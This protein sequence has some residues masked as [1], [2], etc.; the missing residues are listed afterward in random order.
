M[1]EQGCSLET[2]IYVLRKKPVKQMRDMQDY[3]YDMKQQDQKLARTS[4]LNETTEAQ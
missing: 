1:T 4:L 3:S 2:W